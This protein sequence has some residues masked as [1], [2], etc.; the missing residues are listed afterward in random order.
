MS[1]QKLVYVIYH[2]EDKDVNRYL[3]SLDEIREFEVIVS[4]DLEDDRSSHVSTDKR[5]RISLQPSQNA[6]FRD[7]D[8]LVQDQFESV[9][10][11]H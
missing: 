3:D 10:F 4:I 5:T 2:D 9:W 11:D 7:V 6:T 1:N 8:N